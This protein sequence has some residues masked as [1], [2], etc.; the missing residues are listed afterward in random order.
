[1]WHS[2]DVECSGH[3]N[4]FEHFDLDGFD[5]FDLAQK[6]EPSAVE[7]EESR[8][9]PSTG[10]EAYAEPF[11]VMHVSVRKLDRVVAPDSVEYRLPRSKW[12][13]ASGVSNEDFTTLQDAAEA[14][15]RVNLAALRQLRDR[16]LVGNDP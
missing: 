15:L 9:S 7:S 13:G 11:L 2:V 6:V 16:S 12:R 1:M 3:Q 14:D 8:T 4:G 5:G 10:I